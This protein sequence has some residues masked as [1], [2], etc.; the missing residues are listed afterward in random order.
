MRQETIN[1]NMGLFKEAREL[2]KKIQADI[3]NQMMNKE[4]S[5]PVISESH[6]KKAEETTAAQPVAA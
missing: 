4:P 2:R 3:H 5:Q 6:N 1:K